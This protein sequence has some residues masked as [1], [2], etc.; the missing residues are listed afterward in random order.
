QLA[1]ARRLAA[2]MGLRSRAR[3]ALRLRSWPARLRSKTRCG[4]GPTLA[5]SLRAALAVLASSPA[6]EDSLRLWAYARELAARGA[7]GLGR[8]ACARRLAAA[9]GVRS[10]ASS[11]G[12]AREIS[13]C[14]RG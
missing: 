11:A 6:L 4:Y 2:A 14:A 5:S 9:M 1:C 8:L 10:L 3:C 13:G 7:C 12:V